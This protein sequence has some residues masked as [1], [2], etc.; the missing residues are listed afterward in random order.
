MESEE[1]R[2][3]S[4]P[5]LLI[6]KAKQTGASITFVEEAGLLDPVDGVGAFLRWRA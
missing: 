2:R 4:L 6:T 3:A 5:D 1:P